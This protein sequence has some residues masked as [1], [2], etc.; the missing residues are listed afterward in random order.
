MHIP[1]EPDKPLADLLMSQGPILDL[2]FWPG[3]HRVQVNTFLVSKQQEVGDTTASLSAIQ[4]LHPLVVWPWSVEIEQFGLASFDFTE[5]ALI[6]VL[7]LITFVLCK[8]GEGKEA[9]IS[10]DCGTDHMQT[11]WA[12]ASVPR[13]RTEATY[14]CAHGAQYAPA[15]RY[16]TLQ[17]TCV[18]DQPCCQG[19]TDYQQHDDCPLEARHCPTHREV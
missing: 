5:I 6:L 2:I 14:C 3:M 16:H 10:V 8:G 13:D 9:V 1:L 15:Y 12:R 19:S 17:C 4:E 7:F 11:R 18:S